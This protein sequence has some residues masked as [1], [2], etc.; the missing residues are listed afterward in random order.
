MTK[1]E[2]AKKERDERNAAWAA[3]AERVRRLGDLFDALPDSPQKSALLAAM[4][5]R[6]TD[7]YNNVR[8]EHGDVLLEFLPNDYAR[9]LLD[10]YFD[11]DAKA[12]YPTQATPKEDGDAGKVQDQP[13]PESRSNWKFATE[14][15]CAGSR[16]ATDS[17]EPSQPR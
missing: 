6:I 15:Q 16:E 17:S 7:L 12:P 11:D 14:G 8:F 9:Q 1:A 5:D 4:T 10:W 3:E 2:R 13:S